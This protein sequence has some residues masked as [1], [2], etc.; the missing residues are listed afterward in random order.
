MTSLVTVLD[1]PYPSAGGSVELFL[2]LYSGA[3]AAFPAR[4]F[5]LAPTEPTPP[6]TP[7]GIELLHVPGKS[8]TDPGFTPYVGRLAHA[9]KTAAGPANPQLLHLHHLAFGAT[10]ALL[11]AFPDR[12]GIAFVHGTDLLFAEQHRDQRS[13]LTHAARAAT[14]IVVPTWAMADRLRT[15]TPNID[16]H[17]IHRIPWGIPDQLLDSPPQHRP[18]RPGTP[19]R[20]LYAGRLTE[21][22]GVDLLLRA[23]T[24]APRIEL[25]VAA[26]R[27]QYTALADRLRTTHP[28]GPPIRYL[29]WFPRHRLWSVMA[30]HDLLAM[31]STTLEAMGLVAL[32]AQACGL[33][34]LY[35]PVPGLTE[36][37]GD[38]AQTT[39]FRTP[40]IAARTLELLSDST[41]LLGEL[42]DAGRANAARH[43]LSTTIRAITELGTTL[44]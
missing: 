29:G 12:P 39:D 17:K 37:L 1:L 36:A 19:L 42:R 41:S 20:V 5:M 38:T 32:E 14:T 26:P 35:Q 2:D 44:T 15:I 22:K 23:V 21:E 11:H 13:V 3:P 30:D 4:A 25:S 6:E 9:I 34:V 24:L 27:A 28:A 18:R 31:P 16:P 7:T 8:I 43:R 33:P 40:H 10:P